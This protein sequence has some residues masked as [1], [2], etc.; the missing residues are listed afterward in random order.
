MF[1]TQVEHLLDLDYVARAGVRT[2]HHH[3]LREVLPLLA[4]Q[5]FKHLDGSV[6]KGLLSQEQQAQAQAE[7]FAEGVVNFFF[8][9]L[10]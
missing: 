8:F 5:A 6:S 1:S 9:H 4:L 7:K 10:H 2:G 3:D